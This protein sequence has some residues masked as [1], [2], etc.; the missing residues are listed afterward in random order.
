MMFGSWPRKGLAVVGGRLV[1][2]AFAAVAMGAFQEKSKRI[3]VRG[4][5]EPSA[6]VSVR[7]G[8]K[9]SAVA[10][11]V[12]GTTRRRFSDLSE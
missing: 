6:T 3:A 1:A 10:F 9:R 7:G 2:L 8:R 11:S 5:E 4:G 12:R